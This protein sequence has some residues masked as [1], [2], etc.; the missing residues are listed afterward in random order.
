[1]GCCSSSY[2]SIKKFDGNDITEDIWFEIFLHLYHYEIFKFRCVSKLWFSIL[3]NPNFMNKWYK[4]NNVSLPWVL[5]SYA[6]KLDNKLR[7]FLAIAY[8]DPQF[9]SRDR[10]DFLFHFG[11]QHSSYWNDQLFIIGSSCGLVLWTKNIYNK[12]TYYVC[13]P[14]T[15]QW[16]SLPPP[17][18]RENN[19]SVTGII[20]DECF[21]SS[22][23]SRSY[24]V[25]RIPK[26]AAAKEFKVEVFCSELGEWNMYDVSCPEYVT[27][28]NSL[29]GNHFTH[30]GVLYWFQQRN[31]NILAVC[32][33]GNTNHGTHGND[34]MLINMPDRAVDGDINYF[35]EC[36]VQSEG[37]I[38][39]ARFKVTERSLS[40][41][42]LDGGWYMLHKDIRIQDRLEGENG[43]NLITE[44]EVVGMSPVDKNVVILGSEK[45]IWAYNTKTRV[46]EQE[47]HPGK[48]K[49]TT[50]ATSI[51]QMRQYFRDLIGVNYYLMD[52]EI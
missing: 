6:D 5:V 37:L 12:I 38:C 20:C 16:I 22:P 35:S 11:S 19:C 49:K 25:I 29:Y 9:I 14:I 36:L 24:K 40:V 30:N 50:L 32:V 28:D 15:K 45:Y 3:S 2:S 21:S 41:W 43:F 18:Q 7:R 23:H 51:K 42:V 13:E 17:P 26:F 47:C 46:Y 52:I 33:N 44:I 31:R 34:C 39:F 1:M 27:W 8:S 48:S 10:T 4:H